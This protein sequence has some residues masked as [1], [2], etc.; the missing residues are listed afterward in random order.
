[1]AVTE[2]RAPE[3]GAPESRAPTGSAAESYGQILRSTAL[4]GASS[5]I[6]VGFGIIRAK[7]M[8][9][10]LGPAGV[11]LIG[12]FNSLSD[13]CFTAAGMG[14]QESGVR[15]IASVRSS[16]DDTGIARTVSVV[17]RLSLVLGLAGAVLLVLV[18]QPLADL[19]FG[20]PWRSGA[21]AMLGIAVGL[22]IATGGQIALLQGM[23]RVADLAKLGVLSAFFS[24][25]IAI[26]LVYW[27]GEDGIVPSLVGMA[28][29]TLLTSWWYARKVGI[30][31]RRLRIW[32]IAEEASPLLKLGFAF[33]AS[34]LLT[35]GAA[36]LVRLIVLHNS[37]VD[38]AG[39]YQAAWVLGGIY[40]SFILQSMGVD[41][42]PRLTAVADSDEDCGRLV[43]E[44]ARVSL[45]LAAPGVLATLT[46]APLVMIVFYSAAFQPASDLL[47]WIC[48]G[49][50]L[51]IIAWPMGFI[52]LARGAQK[53]FFWTE[54]AA[55]TVNVGLAY[56][57]VRAI[58]LDGAGMAFF[59]LY[60]WHSVLIYVIVRRIAG[61]RWSG[62]NVR[63]GVAMLALTA[64]VFAS[65]EMLPTVPAMAIGSV[66]TIGCGVYCL[67]SLLSIL[68]PDHALVRK[69]P[70]FLKSA[71]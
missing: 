66:T 54:V 6:N 43:N 23:R 24:A 39:F 68:G 25:V 32:E 20:E 22:R 37:G 1:M 69:L 49:M 10:L 65:T 51:R 16:G 33:M 4:I 35:A 34:G 45:L 5:L 28:A 30:Q 50:M 27:L 13:L 15:Q 44:Q 17:R 11:G 67:R 19:T 46:F 47:R 9:V 29:A 8:A 12:I 58:G 53:I 59:G 62:E 41:F 2:S 7:A 18:S 61:F 52:V 60:V 63:L 26:P 71:L 70:R 48:L 64:V 38:E 36:Y 56:V 31:T 55:T 21:I 14:V 3:S 57:L 42:Y 40:A